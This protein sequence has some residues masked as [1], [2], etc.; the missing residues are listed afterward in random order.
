[1]AS[2]I[3]P[4]LNTIPG[5]NVAYV[6]PACAGGNTSACWT[7]PANATAS[8]LANLPKFDVY[9][10]FFFYLISIAI[11]ASVVLLPSSPMSI[12]ITFI[13]M[14]ISVLVSLELSNAIRSIFT[15]AILANA[16]LLFPNTISLFANFPEYEPLFFFIYLI[17]IAAKSKLGGNQGIGGGNARATIG[18]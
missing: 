10:V 11:L 7:S 16:V 18:I 4:V 17:L 3:T 2:R 14:I 12:A 5:Y 13:V 6:T 9:I 1:M 8:V 15:Q